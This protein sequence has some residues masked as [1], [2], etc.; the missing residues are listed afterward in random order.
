M[1]GP[2]C[3]VEIRMQKTKRTTQALELARVRAGVLTVSPVAGPDPT[4]WR[5]TFEPDPEPW[6]PIVVIGNP[7]GH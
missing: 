7:L 3:I 5:P 4:P 2:T 1:E 6:R